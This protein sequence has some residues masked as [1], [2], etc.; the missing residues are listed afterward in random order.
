MANY[1]LYPLNDLGRVTGAVAFSREDEAAQA[2]R[3]Y[4][5]AGDAA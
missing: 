1:R 5:Q 4:A 2:T 3:R